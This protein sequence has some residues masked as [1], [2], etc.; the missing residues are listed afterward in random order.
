MD[1][2]PQAAG[3]SDYQVS[4]QDI[5]DWEHEYGRIQAGSRVSIL[6]YEECYI[7]CMTEEYDNSVK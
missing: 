1:L 4:E 3:N 6:L 7:A 2:A 5:L